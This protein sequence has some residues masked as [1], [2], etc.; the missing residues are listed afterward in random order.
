MSTQA[1][2]RPIGFSPK[3]ISNLVNE[4]VVCQHAEDAAFLWMQRDSAVTAPNFKLK[5]LAKWDERVEAN[6]D[7]LRVAGEVGWQMVL[8]NVDQGETGAIFVA[9]VLALEAP[10][11]ENPRVTKVCKLVDA[12]PEK[13]RELISAFGWVN[14]KALSGKVQGFLDSSNSLWRRVGLRACA[15]HRVDPKAYLDRALS[16]EPLRLRACA[17]RT[18]GEI[19]RRNLLHVLQEEIHLADEE[20]RFWAAWSSVRLGSRGEP[21]KSL[22]KFAMTVSPYQTKAMQLALRVLDNAT[23]AQVLKRLSQSPEHLRYAI[24]GSGIVGDPAYVPWIVQ[25]MS[26][27]EQARVAGESFSTITGVDIAYEDLDGEKP[28]GFEAGPTENPED[29]NV[30]MDSDE[31]LPWPD[32]KLIQDWWDKNAGGFRAGRR[33]LRG[34]EIGLESIRDAMLNGNQR[35]RAAAALE[36]A[37]RNPAEPLFEVRAPAKRQQRQLVS[38]TS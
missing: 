32:P 29:T 21:L 3:E 14:P 17:F 37:I 20:C 19:G 9:G 30:D 36:Q 10:E 15:A 24:V 38:W 12:A 7:G 31:A 27:P 8:A 23:S 5:D 26:I 2:Q 16:E 28:E 35:E 13:A 6:L 11:G 22:L 4:V 18:A 34:K 1:I 25:M 33:Y